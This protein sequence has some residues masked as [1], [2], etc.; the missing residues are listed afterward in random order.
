M[1]PHSLAQRLVNTLKIGGWIG[2]EQKSKTEI[3]SNKTMNV[4]QCKNHLTQNSSL[5]WLRHQ[6]IALPRIYLAGGLLWQELCSSILLAA[7]RHLALVRPG[8]GRVKLKLTGKRWCRYVKAGGHDLHTVPH[9][10]MNYSSDECCSF[11]V[12]QNSEYKIHFI[13]GSNKLQL[14]QFTTHPSPLG[15][16]RNCLN[17]ESQLIEVRSSRT[18]RAVTLIKEASQPHTGAKELRGPPQ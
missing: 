18:D 8:R 4:A 13:P 7:W 16:K 2:K 15:N 12:A 3:F 17:E 6:A 1:F 14:T 5:W 11:L 10:I 9:P